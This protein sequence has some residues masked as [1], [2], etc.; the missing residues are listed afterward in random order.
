MVATAS[1]GAVTIIDSTIA[2]TTTT[3]AATTTVQAV[4]PATGAWSTANRWIA[5]VAVLLLGAGSVLLLVRRR[6]A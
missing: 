6:P 5:L 1:I 2:A 4:L 3:L